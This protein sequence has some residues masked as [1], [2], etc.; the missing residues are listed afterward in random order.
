MELEGNMYVPFTVD[1]G[2]EAN[3]LLEV[4][5]KS[6]KLFSPLKKTGTFL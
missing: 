6:L 1:K 3:I 2:A 5:W 4:V